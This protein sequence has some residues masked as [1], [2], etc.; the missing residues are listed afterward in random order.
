VPLSEL[1]PR[2]GRYARVGLAILVYFIY[3]NLLAAARSWMDKGQLSPRIGMWWIHV[4]ALAAALLL[5]WRQSPPAW[6]RGGGR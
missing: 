5:I 6:W 2:Q 4:L 1:K 3:A